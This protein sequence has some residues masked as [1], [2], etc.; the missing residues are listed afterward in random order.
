VPY[1][2]DFSEYQLSKV[3]F[4]NSSDNLYF[5]KRKL[6][7]LPCLQKVLIKNYYKN[8]EKEIT[9]KGLEE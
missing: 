3:I 9:T 4:K 2:V 7:V 5:S 6:I 8:R 1:T